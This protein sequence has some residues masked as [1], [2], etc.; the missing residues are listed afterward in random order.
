MVLFYL[1][2]K[3]SDLSLFF[4]PLKELLFE[5]GLITRLSVCNTDVTLFLVKEVLE[6]R[7]AYRLWSRSRNVTLLRLVTSEGLS[8][9]TAPLTYLYGLRRITE[10]RRHHYPDHRKPYQVA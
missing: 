4:G 6:E 10:V 2:D 9:V 7:L 5:G 8:C 3:G 1:T